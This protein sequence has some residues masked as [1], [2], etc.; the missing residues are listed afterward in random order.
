MVSRDVMFGR[1]RRR[2]IYIFFTTNGRPEQILFQIPLFIFS[3][4][5]D[6]SASS[7]SGRNAGSE[8][9]D[10]EGE[11]QQAAANETR[12][13]FAFWLN[14]HR[15][16]YSAAACCH[17]APAWIQVNAAEA[18]SNGAA[19]GITGSRFVNRTVALPSGGCGA[20]E[21]Q[22]KPHTDTVKIAC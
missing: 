4:F 22:E 3:V 20:N 13:R 7:L 11:I 9:G 18:L 12:V 6:H 1:R 10:N 8:R 16:G 15:Q 2:N 21:P 17:F 5:H 14:L 19:L